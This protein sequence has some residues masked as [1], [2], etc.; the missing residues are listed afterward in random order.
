MISKVFKDSYEHHRIKAKYFDL[1]VSSDLLALRLEAVSFQLP[2]IQL[3]LQEVTTPS[4]H[5]SLYTVFTV[6][7]LYGVNKRHIKCWL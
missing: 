5:K 2:G 6:T 3:R 7:F 4:P 1:T